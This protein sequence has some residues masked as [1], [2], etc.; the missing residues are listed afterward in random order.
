MQSFSELLY[1]R[2]YVIISLLLFKCY[3]IYAY[4]ICA[5]NCRFCYVEQPKQSI[6]CNPYEV[7]NITIWCIIERPLKT[8][9]EIRWFFSSQNINTTRITS[10]DT[11]YTIQTRNN[12]IS[13]KNISK[14]TSQLFILSP[15]TEGRYWCEVFYNNNGLQRSQSLEVT[16]E[17]DYERYDPC[18]ETTSIVEQ[19]KKCTDI[20]KNSASTCPTPPSPTF[21]ISSKQTSTLTLSTTNT[22]S[23]TIFSFKSIS[24]SYMSSIQVRPTGQIVYQTTTPT[25][26]PAGLQNKE[27]NFHL[28]LYIVA[29]LTGIFGILIIILTVIC[30]ALCL[31]RPKK[32]INKR[33]LFS[34]DNVWYE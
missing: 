25:T 11:R 12:S 33:T 34:D 32:S 31:M 2:R 7:S 13:Q 24:S 27:D 21:T 8:S 30:L 29:G 1:F 6:D 18:T 16:A 14:Q 19:I 4:A 20:V 3:N 28:W 23:N 5:G 22:I 10:S 15:L 26:D 9:L 17:D